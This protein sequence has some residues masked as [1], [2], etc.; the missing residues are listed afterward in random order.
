M[1]L[2]R[3]SLVVLA[4]FALAMPLLAE[5]GPALFK[6]KCAGCHA[7]DGTG[8]PMGKKLGAKPLGGADVQKLTDA[9]LEKTISTGKGKMPAFKT[10]TP[11]E[12]KSL[13]AEIRA[14]AKK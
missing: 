14:F 11:A 5:D 13:V 3:L 9:D 8:S 12:I 10:L 7:A 6:A 1:K 2:F 4:V